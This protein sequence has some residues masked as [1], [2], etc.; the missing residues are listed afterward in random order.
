[1][2]KKQTTVVIVGAMISFAV[3]VDVTM[4]FG[5]ICPRLLF[6]TTNLLIEGLGFLIAWELLVIVLKDKRRGTEGKR[7]M[8]K[9]KVHPSALMLMLFF[10]ITCGLSNLNPTQVGGNITF[11]S[12]CDPRPLQEA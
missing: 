3:L 6:N 2:N 9:G 5:F 7:E 4:M 12:L 10:L 8:G 11:S 1:M